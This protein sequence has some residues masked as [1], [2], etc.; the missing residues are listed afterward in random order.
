MIGRDCMYMRNIRGSVEQPREVQANTGTHSLHFS[1]QQTFKVSRSP[2]C[3]YNPRMAHNE[4]Q[5]LVGAEEADLNKNL[6]RLASDGWKPILMS[7]AVPPAG[8]HA[9]QVVATIIIE[10][11]K[12]EPA[13]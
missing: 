11:E 5:V 7:T 3:A 10:R 9:N 12:K 4:Y 2:A 1:L 6:A 8:H 13:R